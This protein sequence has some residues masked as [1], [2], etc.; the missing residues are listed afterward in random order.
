MVSDQSGKSNIL[1][2]FRNVGIEVDTDNPKIARLVDRVKELEF[3]GYAYDGAEASFELL[4][5]RALH[6]IPEYFSLRSFRVIDERRWNA[7][8][9]LI[10]LSEATI[11][12]QVNGQQFMT[13]GEG[14][15]PVNALDS[16]LRDV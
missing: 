15:G 13:V 14:N 1:A 7:K 11:K 9:E 12:A 5:R 4:A 16:A 3:A 8:D 2:M 6:T 10:T